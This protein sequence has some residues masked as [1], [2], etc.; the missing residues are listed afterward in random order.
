MQSI[1]IRIEGTQGTYLIF[2]SEMYRKI[3][4]YILANNYGWSYGY[5]PHGSSYG[6]INTVTRNMIRI[7]KGGNPPKCIGTG[8][9]KWEMKWRNGCGST[10]HYKASDRQLI[11]GIDWL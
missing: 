2:T 9:E 4:R 3:K 1:K 10:T 7:T 8:Y 11:V 6:Y 5:H